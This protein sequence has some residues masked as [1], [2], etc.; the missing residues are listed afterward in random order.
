MTP[1][2]AK[3][4]TGPTRPL[5]EAY[6]L[7][8]VA[9]AQVS[10]VSSFF[11]PKAMAARLCRRRRPDAKVEKKTSLAEVPAAQCTNLLLE[12]PLQDPWLQHTLS[13]NALHP[14]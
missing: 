1:L 2:V 3:V 11:S 13:H 14:R 12:E 6:C 5:Q 8:C 10:N 7:T 4:W 9:A